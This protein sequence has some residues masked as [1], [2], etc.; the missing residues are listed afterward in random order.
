M[1]GFQVSDSCLLSERLTVLLFPILWFTRKSTSHEH[2]SLDLS[3]QTLLFFD[4]SRFSKLVYREA[5]TCRPWWPR[6]RNSKAEALF[7]GLAL[8]VLD[9]VSVQACR[10]GLISPL[11]LPSF[12]RA[13]QAPPYVEKSRVVSQSS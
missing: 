2:P 5:D 12:P 13:P 9:L 8:R 6:W 10:T 7:E 11:K 3:L 4:F 1:L